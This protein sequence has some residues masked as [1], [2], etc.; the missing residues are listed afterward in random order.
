MDP[1]FYNDKDINP[2]GVS[3]KEVKRQDAN[4]IKAYSQK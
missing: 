2:R 1:R 4:K 3:F